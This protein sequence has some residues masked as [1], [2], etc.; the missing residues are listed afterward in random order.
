[1]ATEVNTEVIPALN[2]SIATVE[3]LAPKLTR[4]IEKCKEIAKETGSSE[5]M[6]T[7][8]GAE[9]SIAAL[10]TSAKELVETLKMLSK[11]YNS[12]AQALGS[13]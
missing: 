4:A 10:S 6:K 3:E 12:V 8:D 1:M 9:E 7:F 13:L 5:L 11:K 2:N